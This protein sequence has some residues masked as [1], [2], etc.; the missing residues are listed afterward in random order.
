LPLSIKVIGG[1]AIFTMQVII[2]YLICV[3]CQ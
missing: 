1:I 2:F 3:S